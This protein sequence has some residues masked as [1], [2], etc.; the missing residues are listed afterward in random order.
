MRFDV[1]INTD[2]HNR[3]VYSFSCFDFRVVLVGWRWEEK[4]PRRRVWTIRHSWDTYRVRDSSAK[5]PP[6]LSAEIKQM[7]VN[8][9]NEMIKV[10][11]WSEWKNLK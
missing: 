6:H 11:T 9:I 8:Q 4:P 3:E 7:A 1:I 10:M 5:E 2:L